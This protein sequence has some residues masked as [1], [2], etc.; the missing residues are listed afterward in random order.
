VIARYREH[1]EHM[2]KLV[3]NPHASVELVEEYRERLTNILETVV[4]GRV[5]LYPGDGHL[6]AELGAEGDV[7]LASAP[8]A[9]RTGVRP[10]I[11][12]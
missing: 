3:R 6:I 11:P 7:E 9:G 5:K 2:E 8:R 4:G 10:S 12:W 1:I